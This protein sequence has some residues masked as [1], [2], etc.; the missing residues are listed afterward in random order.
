MGSLLDA[1]KLPTTT[2]AEIEDGPG[3][4][5]VE[6]VIASASHMVSN[7]KGYIFLLFIQRSSHSKKSFWTILLCQ[8]KDY[9]LN[10]SLHWRLI[11]LW[12][13]TLQGNLIC[14]SQHPYFIFCSDVD[15]GT[16]WLNEVL[17]SLTVKLQQQLINLPL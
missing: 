13:P 16:K 9:F 11:I 14:N 4:C 12:I 1:W 7:S 2:G 6:S 5:E 10:P 15:T 3:A 8:W 17:C